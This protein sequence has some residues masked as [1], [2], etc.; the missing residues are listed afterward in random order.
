MRAEIYNSMDKEIVLT[1]RA[2]EMHQVSFNLSP[3]ALQRVQTGWKDRASVVTLEAQRLG[4]LRFD[5]I[6][7]SPYLWTRLDWSE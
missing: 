2:P 7:Y 4:A 3:G 5:N 1:V 6:A